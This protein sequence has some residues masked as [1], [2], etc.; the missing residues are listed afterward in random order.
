MAH[1]KMHTKAQAKI[2]ANQRTMAKNTLR[3][4]QPGAMANIMKRLKGK[5][6]WTAK[7]ISAM[8]KELSEETPHQRKMRMPAGRTNLTA[9]KVALKRL[10]GK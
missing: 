9:S 6:K 4:A 1:N 10:K 3:S 7:E 8:K 2:R 5:G